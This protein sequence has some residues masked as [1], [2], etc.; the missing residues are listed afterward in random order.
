ML[1]LEAEAQ[2]SSWC[3]EMEPCWSGVAPCAGGKAEKKRLEHELVPEL[4]GTT[5]MADGDE[6]TSATVTGS[7]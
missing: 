1:D 4:A 3:K 5:Y 7:N 2:D 6:R